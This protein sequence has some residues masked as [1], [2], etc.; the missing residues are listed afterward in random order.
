ML[1]IASQG[2]RGFERVEPPFFGWILYPKS[3]VLS[4]LG[5]AAAGCGPRVHL[6]AVSAG[7]AAGC[8]LW[9]AQPQAP[10]RIPRA[11]GTAAPAKKLILTNPKP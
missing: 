11:A 5:V 8:M 7:V 1:T 6:V 10:A 9:A 2:P 4:S 3:Y